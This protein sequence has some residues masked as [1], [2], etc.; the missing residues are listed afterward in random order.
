MEIDPNS[1]PPLAI[2]RTR[3]KLRESLGFNGRQLMEECDEKKFIFETKLWLV[4][5]SVTF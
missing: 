5:S 1:D 3:G 4:L 2:N